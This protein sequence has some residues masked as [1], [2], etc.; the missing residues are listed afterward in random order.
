[1]MPMAPQ[2]KTESAKTEQS[3]FRLL[4]NFLTGF[5]LSGL[6]IFVYLSL[7]VDMTYGSL[8]A[9]GNGKLAVAAIVP[10][11]CGLLAVFFKDRVISFLS[12]L[13]ESANLPF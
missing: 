12:S 2:E 7:S 6:P 8:A 3:S 13:L 9:V 10:V 5:L 1:M 11:V 4:Q